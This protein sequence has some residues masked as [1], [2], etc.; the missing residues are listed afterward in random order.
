MN[1]IHTALFQAALQTPYVKDFFTLCSS[2]SSDLIL[3][4]LLILHLIRHRLDLHILLSLYAVHGVFC[5]P[6]IQ[7]SV[8]SLCECGLKTLT[9]GVLAVKADVILIQYEAGP[10]EGLHS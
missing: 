1:I 2:V 3:R 5:R 6:A 9:L 4:T 10:V 7:N 8:L